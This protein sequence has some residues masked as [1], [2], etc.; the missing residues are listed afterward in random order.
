[1]PVI[2]FIT[3]NQFDYVVATCL[4]SPQLTLTTK[5]K[6]MH[7]QFPALKSHNNNK[8]NITY[9]HQP[10]MLTNTPPVQTK[11]SYKSVP[12]IRKVQPGF[13][14]PCPLTLKLNNTSVP[15]TNRYKA[16][17]WDVTYAITYIT[18]LILQNIKIQ[19]YKMKLYNRS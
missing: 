12:T 17:S 11:P 9:P 3:T 15:N 18:T 2:I 14:S 6:G 16:Q 5:T 4:F 19:Q 1:M 13:Q 8:G 7:I 10:K